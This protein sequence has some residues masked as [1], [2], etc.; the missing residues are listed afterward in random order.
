MDHISVTAGVKQHM[1]CELRLFAR[2]AIGR[3]RNEKSK[4]R[5]ARPKPHAK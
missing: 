5:N 4:A 3:R 1:R 2:K